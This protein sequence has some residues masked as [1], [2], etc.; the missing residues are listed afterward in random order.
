MAPSNSNPKAS[1]RQKSEVD[2]DDTS[3]PEPSQ[4][5]A[6]TASPRFLVISSTEERQVSSLSP[7]V[8]EKALH[9]IAGIPRSIKKL[10]SGDLLVEYASRKQIESLLRTKKFFDLDVKVS[11]HSSL[12]T[13]KGVVRC[14]DLRGCS[15]QEILENMREQGVI[16]VRRIKVRRDGS[17][18]DTNTFILTFNTSTLP[19]QVKVAFLRVDVDAYIPN[20]LRCYRCQVFGHHEDRCKKQTICAN[21]GQP[22]HSADETDCKNAAKC[23]NCKGDHPANSKLCQAWHTEK[24]ILKVKY[25]R[26]VSFPEARKVVEG[27]TAAPGKSYASITKTASVTVSC[28]DAATQTDPV[29]IT[30][31]PQS[32]SYNAASQAS[33]EDHLSQKEQAKQQKADKKLEKI[34]RDTIVKNDKNKQNSSDRPPDPKSRGKE[35]LQSDREPKG[36]NDPI[37]QHNRWSAFE[38]MD[39]EESPSCL[40][41]G[42]L[43]RIP[44]S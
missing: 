33:T 34:V 25:T 24:E 42:T 13:S 7:F 16:A 4:P 15:E 38:D 36:S 17:L 37:R 32:S 30:P 31:A 18:K 44:T 26:N 10:R 27:Y 19:K 43:N 35:K 1:K 22:Q 8:I 28:V 2:S 9:G 29:L 11:L 14:P 23:V 39:A 3:E 6:P 21:C 41:R 12:N 40:P 5:T 20:P